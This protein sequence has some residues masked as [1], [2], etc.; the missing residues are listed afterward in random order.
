MS[1]VQEKWL[2]EQ[3]KDQQARIQHLEEALRHA[4]WV[5]ESYTAGQEKYLVP[6]DAALASL[7][8]ARAEAPEKEGEDGLD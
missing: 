3:Y 2:W 1:D 4:R 6:I 5:I 7:R 8:E